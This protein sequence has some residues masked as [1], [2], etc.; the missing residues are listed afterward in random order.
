MLT[1]QHFVVAAGIDCL[2]FAGLH[3]IDHNVF[4]IF[5]GSLVLVQ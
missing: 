1:G 3:A 2:D 4:V 5:C